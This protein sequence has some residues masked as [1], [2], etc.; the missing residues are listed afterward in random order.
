MKSREKLMIVVGAFSLP[1]PSGFLLSF[2]WMLAVLIGSAVNAGPLPPIANGTVTVR[3]ETVAAGLA[4]T[5]QSVNQVFPTDLDPVPDGS[6]R[7]AIG[8]LGGLVRI[9]DGSGSLLGTPFLNTTNANT[10]VTGTFGMTGIAFHPDYSNVASSGFGKFYTLT[11]ENL[12]SAPATFSSTVTTGS[13]PNDNV[14]IEWTDNNVLDDV[15]SGSQREVM[16]IAQPDGSHNTN[17]LAFDSNGLLHIAVGDGGFRN[18]VPTQQDTVFGDNAPDLTKIFG[19]VLRIDP[20]QP[21]LGDPQSSTNGQY[22]IPVGQGLPGALPEIYSYGHRN[23]YRLN[24]DSQT[25]DLYV[26]EVGQF[27]IEEVNQVVQGANYGWPDKEGSFLFDRTNGNAVQPDLDNN[28]NG[29]GD[30]AEANGYTDPIF[31]YD[32]DD[33]V[34]VTGGFVYRG[35]A[36]PE[37]QGKYIYSDLLGSFGLYYGDPTTGVT[38]RAILQ[39]G[40]EAML[41][42]VISIGEDA[43]GELYL[44]GNSGGDGRVQQ[45]VP[46]QPPAPD[47]TPGLAQ[48]NEVVPLAVPADGNMFLFIDDMG[49]AADSTFVAINTGITIVPGLEYSIEAATGH[50]VG[51][52]LSNQSIQAWST[53]D[54][55]IASRQF[56]GQSFSGDGTWIDS[57]DGEWADNEFVFTAT[58]DHANEELIILVTNF[59]GDP[60]GTSGFAY[61]DNFRVLE[62]GAMMFQDGFEIGLAP[63][64]DG[65]VADAG[66]DLGNSSLANSGVAA[67]FSYAADFD[68][69]GD[70]DDNDLTILL[71]AYGQSAGGDANNDG[72]TNGPDFLFW[73]RQNGLGVVSP[74]SAQPIPEPSS[75]VTIVMAV[76]L[77]VPPRRL[78]RSNT[79]RRALRE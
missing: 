31:E 73:Q 61:W 38:E 11:T 40:S 65:E 62:D 18:D 37:L 54:G 41:G 57:P 4:G 2:T 45:I 68:L 28:N 78:K 46:A 21:S 43:N 35:V 10:N 47:P 39:A 58:G 20:L 15:V 36:I 64:F 9:V 34:S 5:V 6:G 69:D 25:G 23:P 79:Q 33:G 50:A 66:W 51:D 48:F 53:P 77:L 30:V 24:F 60:P 76:L 32:H 59:S 70:V 55:S 14:L 16:R 13:G 52:V 17:D 7:M 71:D 26:G 27:Q 75:A 8:T 72:N 56:I 44:L 63:G 74:P 1:V 22:R 67:A 12:G 29:I 42:Q 3:L 19:K 49:G